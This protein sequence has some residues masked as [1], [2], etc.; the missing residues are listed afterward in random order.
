MDF[1]DLE[2]VAAHMRLLEVEKGEH[3]LKVNTHANA[4][5]FILQGQLEACL[6]GKGKQQIL[7]LGNYAHSTPSARAGSFFEPEINK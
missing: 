3:V 1:K 2:V 7:T 5:L 4:V 6:K